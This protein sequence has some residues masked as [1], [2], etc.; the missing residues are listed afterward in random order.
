[1]IGVLSK[2]THK[3]LITGGMGYLGSRI[4]N[5][6]AKEYDLDIYL[7]THTTQPILPKWLS[8]DKL[9][10]LDITTNN[11]K[12]LLEACKGIQTII[13]LA[14]LGEIDSKTDPE[15]AFIVNSLG[16]LKLLQAAKTTGIKRF[17]YFSTAHVYGSPLMG[18]I[19]EQT[20]PRPITPYAIT[21]KA[22][23]D[24]VLAAHNKK[25]FCGIVLR[26]SNAFGAPAHPKINQWTLVVNDLCKQAVIDKKI[27]LKSSGLQIRDFITI[28]DTARAVAHFLYLPINECDNGLFNV[29]GE[30]P[31]R[32]IDLAEMI[33][34]RCNKILAFKPEIIKQDKSQDEN[35]DTLNY[36]IDKLISTGFKLKR[37]CEKEIDD[38]INFCLNL[39]EGKT[40][41]TTLTG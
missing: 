5:H 12:K 30:N 28:E 32:I 21:H 41:S 11:N 40:T 2:M 16:T 29:G 4:A 25:T 6:L 15:K 18:K 26:V 36:S 23:E 38:T 20:I 27:V 13:H 22:A 19:T 24:F 9:I 37:N 1:M 39:F 34:A 14:A 31:L 33:S 10:S 35:S 8:K 3:I 17:I 7:T